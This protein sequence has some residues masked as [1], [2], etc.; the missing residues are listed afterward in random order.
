MLFEDIRNP[1]DMGR[2]RL[3]Y[4][5]PD[6]DRDPILKHINLYAY[7]KEIMEQTPEAAISPYG[8]IER[9]DGQPIL[10]PPQQQASPQ[11]TMQ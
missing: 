11:M 4:L 5:L 7:G 1:E 2:Y 3:T 8:L 9:T 10:A 6:E